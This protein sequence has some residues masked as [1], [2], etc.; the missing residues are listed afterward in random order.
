MHHSIHV[1]PFIHVYKYHNHMH[2]LQLYVRC[3]MHFRPCT[4]AFLLKS[5]AQYIIHF[6]LI[7]LAMK[8]RAEISAKM[9]PVIPIISPWAHFTNDSSIALEIVIIVLQITAF[10][11]CAPNCDELQLCTLSESIIIQM[12]VRYT[13]RSECL[14]LSSF[15][16]LYFIQ[17][18]RLCIFSLYSS[19]S[20]NDC[21]NVC[22]SSRYHHQFEN[23]NH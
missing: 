3:H 11:T 9:S 4:F 15:S 8:R 7:Y 18:M 17:Q 20:M 14:R 19:L 13:L 21:E 12:I 1:Q 2:V 23:M 5:Y 16:Q 10:I 6:R 22:T